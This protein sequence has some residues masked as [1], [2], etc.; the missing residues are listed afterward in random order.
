MRNSCSKALNT[1]KLKKKVYSRQDFLKL[2][3]K[4]M[5]ITPYRNLEKKI[6]D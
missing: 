2:K 4:K 6:I 3:V 1:E 5:R